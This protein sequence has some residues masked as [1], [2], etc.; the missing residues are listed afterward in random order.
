MN[1]RITTIV[2]VLLLSL[3]ALA[4]NAKVQITGTVSD[5]IGPVPGVTI[6]E[7]GNITNGTVTDADGK[8]SI[9]VSKGATLKFICLGY[10]EIEE[11]IGGRTVIDVQLKE[12][13]Q[14]LAAAEVVSVGYGSVARRDLT[15]SVSKVNMDDIVK[16]SPMNFD[17]A[18]AG[19]VAGVVVTT[20]DGA[21]GSEASI[22]IRGNNSLTQSSE[23]LYV[24]DGFPT[25]SSFASSLNP[26]DIES[27]DVLKDASAAAIYGARGANGVIVI[28]TKKGSIGAPK[29]SF[30]ASWSVGKI[31]K[32]VDLLDGYE[33]VRLDDLY[34]QNSTGSN[35]SYFMGYDELGTPVYDMYT[36]EDYRSQ[37]Q[38]DW[39]DQ[40]YRTAFSQN[41]NISLSGGTD[42][43]MYSVSLGYTDQNGIL[44]ASNFNRL[45]GTVKLSQK[46]GK[47][48]T[49]DF[50]ASFS[51]ATTNGTQP[52]SSDSQTVVSSYLL[53]SIWGYRPTKPLRD[54]L[55]TD[56]N[57]DTFINELVDTEVSTPDSFRFN[58]YANVMNQYK[59]KVRD[60][61]NANLALSFQILPSLKLRIS[62]GCNI[63][64]TTDETFNNSKT[65][66]GHPAS[67]LGQGVNGKILYDD[68]TSWLNE[69]IL[70]YDKTF[71]LDH[72]FQALGGITFQG[73][74]STHQGVAANHIKS[75]QLGLAGMN[76]G[77]YQT[78]TPYIRDWTL[79]SGLARVN[80][81]YAHKY[82]LTASFR[83]DGSSKFPTANRWGFF[84]SAS[85]AWSFG[86][87]PWVKSV[88]WI[89]VGKLRLSYGMTGNNRTTT[90][91]D[92][93]TNF[94]TTPGSSESLDYVLD[95][96]TVS[97]YYRQNLAN[98]N[99]KWETTTQTD[100]GLDFAVL[101]SRIGLTADIYLKD[102]RDL[103]LDATMP[104]SSGYAS[105]MI[106]VGSIRNKGLE[107]SLNVI[108]V[109]TRSFTWTSTFNIAMNR[110]TVTG[111]SSNQTSLVST[112]NWNSKYS[113][114]YPYVTK[115]GLPTGL[116]Y[117][118]IYEGTYKLSEF[119]N[120]TT[121]K[122]GIPYLEELNR[123]S[124]RPGDP[125]YKDVN[126][127]GIINDADRVVIGQG[128]PL[129]TGGWNNTFAAFGFDLSVFMNWS[130]GNDIL[131]ANRLVFEN[132]DGTQLNQFA[133]MNNCYTTSNETDIPRPGASGMNYY[134][135]RV[136]EDGSFL[137]LKT[138]TLGYT[139]PSKTIQNAHIS[140][141][142]LYL[143]ADN[144][145]TIT[146]YSGSDPEVSTR[147]SVLTP[148]FDWSA[149]PRAKSL[150][151]GVS[152]SF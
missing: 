87:E 71:G 130:Y 115:V 90:P 118:Y 100:L 112:V 23:P 50:N 12:D 64:K 29:V 133:T 129:H 25:E 1:K 37:G 95:G 40:V 24:I 73:E 141:L 152:M 96:Q 134:S 45:N 123:D 150:I 131:N 59:K 132:C 31:S 33:Y 34:A 66:S 72:N 114:Q 119:S 6:C 104:T 46:L 121:L 109:R 54:G 78:V 101:D 18:L 43:T 147:N 107:I 2:T 20:S 3:T 5:D 8:Y 69:N 111:L 91:Y 44:K 102:T 136:V 70:T 81:N 58:P 98:P 47:I 117:G 19:R 4:Q 148:G 68:V 36:L 126:G 30:S 41:Y 143:T 138:I 49:A 144:I 53:Y 22:T 146:N 39:Q 76:T 28:T 56:E 17:Q 125:K 26:S 85:V 120:G 99:L 14:M 48:T 122:E 9:S 80:Y 52:S 106:N 16:S 38:V 62:G 13:A 103:L 79:I 75:E 89:S 32:K 67:P 135:S 15:G 21:V 149:Y 128:Q 55:L 139:F 11:K 124:I 108:P 86:N 74:H 42:K 77:S 51:R 140:T 27:I 151:L 83:A 7:S 94:T 35:S 82:Y 88:S 137:R 105:A 113:S 110:N 92:Y 93:Y 57:M 63:T 61:F 84:P 116:M 97:G 10:T 65:M 142:R 127:D 60:Y 145:F